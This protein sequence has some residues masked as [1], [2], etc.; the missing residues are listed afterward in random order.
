MTIDA[1]EDAPTL[2][3]QK[4]SKARGLIMVA[5][6]RLIQNKGYKNAKMREIAEAAKISYQTLY[7]Y[8]P[9]KSTIAQSL[10][11]DE[12]GIC[13][14]KPLS[15]PADQAHL[16]LMACLQQLVTGLFDTA[17]D[18]HRGLWREVILDI[19]REPA[20][21]YC[22]LSMLDPA[23]PEK[24]FLLFRE[25]T[26]GASSTQQVSLAALNCRLID[27]NLQQYL[28]QPSLSRWEA[29]KVLLDQLSLVNNQPVTSRV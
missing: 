3:D 11:H 17:A 7:N 29:S 10:L 6:K 5:A 4:R 13:T 18:K 22:A 14:E 20:N 27:A 21:D 26:N 19:I 16:D 15:L 25:K 24:I 9:T 12:L 1:N 28:L 2:R 23:G 8:F